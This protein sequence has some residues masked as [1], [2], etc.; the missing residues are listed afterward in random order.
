M[1]DD[2]LTSLSTYSDQWESV[3]ADEM[4]DKIQE[5]ANNIPH[6]EEVDIWL[7]FRWEDFFDEKIDD[8]TVDQMLWLEKHRNAKCLEASGTPFDEDL[9]EG[10]VKVLKFP[11]YEMNFN[12]DLKIDDPDHNKYALSKWAYGCM[13]LDVF[14][15]K[16]KK[17]V[18]C[19]S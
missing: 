1:I 2:G 10:E 9:E 5:L 17:D 4:L 13:G 14:G 16:N 11:R 12:I 6:R 3:S 15:G 8:K 7:V 18:F 19:A